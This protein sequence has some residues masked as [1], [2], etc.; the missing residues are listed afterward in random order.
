[1]LVAA[2][3]A[4]VCGPVQVEGQLGV[5]FADSFAANSDTQFL[6]IMN[7]RWMQN[8]IQ[9]NQITDL[10]N[11]GWKRGLRVTGDPGTHLIGWEDVYI[12]AFE[13]DLLMQAKDDIDGN[14]FDIDG[15]AEM[16]FEI[17]SVRRNVEMH[18]AND[19]DIN[20][21]YNSIF[22]GDRNVLVQ[23]Q[24]DDIETTSQHLTDVN[25]GTDIEIT[26]HNNVLLDSTTA[27]VQLNAQERDILMQAHDDVKLV[28]V[29]GD[30]E[31][32]SARDIN[33]C[34]QQDIRFLNQDPSEVLSPL[35]TEGGIIFITDCGE[36]QNYVAY[37]ENG[38]ATAGVDAG[39]KNIVLVSQGTEGGVVVSSAT[40]PP[41]NDV[42]TVSPRDII[43]HAARVRESDGQG[44]S[45]M[46]TE[47]TTES[48]ADVSLDVN[49]DIVSGRISAVAAALT[50]GVRF[51]T[52]GVDFDQQIRDNV[53]LYSVEFQAAGAG[54]GGKGAIL[55]TSTGEVT[56]AEAQNRDIV[57]H[58]PHSEPFSSSQALSVDGNN[59]VGG[60]IG[61]L[62]SR[63]RDSVTPLP[64]EIFVYSNSNPRGGAAGRKNGDVEFLTGSRTSTYTESPG[65]R[66]L[67][68]SNSPS[69]A[70]TSGIL[71]IA[72][73]VGSDGS[74]F[75][76][77]NN[78]ILVSAGRASGSMTISSGSEL[79][80]PRGNQ[81]ADIH[82]QA[83][84]VTGSVQFATGS[85]ELD[86]GFNR[87][88][89]F[90]ARAVTKSSVDDDKQRA[91]SLAF[92]VGAVKTEGGPPSI[93]F[94][95]DYG[96][97]V[98]LLAAEDEGGIA[99]LASDLSDS[100]I[101]ST[102]G[103]DG[104]PNTSRSVAAGFNDVAIATDNSHGG[105]IFNSGNTDKLPVAQKGGVIFL[106]PETTGGIFFGTA[107]VPV[108]NVEDNDVFAVS[109]GGVLI[110]TDLP[111][112]MQPRDADIGIISNAPTGGILQSL[113][114]L[115]SLPSLTPQAVSGS[116]LTVVDARL[117]GGIGI[118]TG[119]PSTTPSVD[120]GLPIDK[121]NI[122]INARRDSTPADG[123]VLTAGAV[124]VATGSVE[125]RD[126]ANPT[127]Q[128]IQ[129]NVV[130]NSNGKDGGIV[131]SLGDS[132]PAQ[133][134]SI[135]TN[136]D[137]RYEA[138]IA[139][140]TGAFTATLEQND[141]MLVSQN[142]GVAVGTG[143]VTTS[144]GGGPGNLLID[145]NDILVNAR[146]PNAGLVVS[147]GATVPQAQD[148][149]IILANMANRNTINGE[150]RG[151]IGFFTSNSNAAQNDIVVGENIILNS[152]TATN[153]GIL[154]RLGER[155]GTSTDAPDRHL[156][157][158]A[159]RDADG[160]GAN[161]A[162]DTLPQL[163]ALG[164]SKSVSFSAPGDRGGVTVSVID[165]SNDIFTTPVDHAISLICETVDSCSTLIA[166]GGTDDAADPSPIVPEPLDVVIQAS[167]LS[168]RLD[169]DDVGGV[170]MVAGQA[171]GSKFTSDNNIVVHAQFNDGGVTVAAGAT[172]PP[173]FDN[174]V[175]LH[176]PGAS[177]ESGILSGILSQVGFGDT[178]DLSDNLSND[179]IVFYTTEGDIRVESTGYN[180]EIDVRTL[181]GVAGTIDVKAGTVFV[182][183]K[184]D[185]PGVTSQPT[186]G[187]TSAPSGSVELTAGR[188]YVEEAEQVASFKSF[189][190]N[191]DITSLQNDVLINA[192]SGAVQIGA[193]GANSFGEG[194][195]G[196]VE[197]VANS[198]PTNGD[199]NDFSDIRF[200]GAELVQVSTTAGGSDI[201]VKSSTRTIQLA[202][203]VVW[204]TYPSDSARDIELFSDAGLTLTASG[205]AD[206][207]H[208]IIAQG[209][210]NLQSLDG[211][212]SFDALATAP[213]T[214]PVQGEVR[215]TSSN[216]L[217]S[218]ANAQHD[219]E[220]DV[221]D[222]LLRTNTGVAGLCFAAGLDNTLCDQF[223]NFNNAILFESQK[224]TLITSTTGHTVTAK[225]EGI[226]VNVPSTGGGIAV[227]ARSRADP[228]ATILPKQVQFSADGQF[229]TVA[230][231]G[232]FDSEF[233]LIHRVDEESL[234]YV[235]E[236]GGV[237]LYASNNDLNRAAE[238]LPGSRIP[239]DAQ[240]LVKAD[241]NI[242]FEALNGHVLF[243]EDNSVDT[244]MN[245]GGNIELQGRGGL[246]VLA[247]ENSQPGLKAPVLGQVFVLSLD[248]NESDGGDITMVGNS[249]INM[250]VT[251]GDLQ[252]VAYGINPVNAARPKS[253]VFHTIST[254]PVGTTNFD[255]ILDSLAEV[256]VQ[257]TTQLRGYGR[258]VKAQTLNSGAVV[259]YST[260]DVPDVPD[261]DNVE[262]HADGDAFITTTTTEATALKAA[263]LDGDIFVAT[264]GAKADVTFT[265]TEMTTNAG[266]IDLRGIGGVRILAATAGTA[267]NG[268]V[269]TTTTDATGTDGYGQVRFLGGGNVIVQSGDGKSTTTDSN[270]INVQLEAAAAEGS[271][272][273]S[274]APTQIQ[275]SVT[276]KANA[277]LED[278]FIR[279][280]LNV[281]GDTQFSGGPT[282]VRGSLSTKTKNEN[283]AGNG[284]TFQSQYVEFSSSNRLTSFLNHLVQGSD[285]P[286]V[287]GGFFS[288][289][290]NGN[291]FDR[292]VTFDFVN[293]Q[294]GN[295]VG[296]ATTDTQQINFHSTTTFDPQSNTAVNVKVRVSND[297]QFRGETIRTR[298]APVT[299]NTGDVV[300]QQGSFINHVLPATTA[301]A[302]QTD[303]F[304]PAF[305]AQGGDF[306]G[307]AA[308][309]ERGSTMIMPG[310]GIFGFGQNANGIS[311]SSGLAS[312]ST[313]YTFV[314]R[315]QDVTCP[316]SSTAINPTWTSPLDSH[317]GGIAST[318]LPG[319]DAFYAPSG[320]LIVSDGLVGSHTA[321]LEVGGLYG[322]RYTDTLNSRVDYK[323]DANTAPNPNYVLF[324]DGANSDLQTI[325]T[326]IPV[327]LMGDEQP[328]SDATFTIGTGTGRG[329]RARFFGKDINV[330]A[331]KAS[332]DTNTEGLFV[333]NMRY[334]WLEQ[335]IGI[336][337][338]PANNG[339]FMCAV[340]AANT[341]L[342]DFTRTGPVNTVTFNLF[343]YCDGP[344]DSSTAVSQ[345]SCCDGA[346]CPPSACDNTHNTELAAVS[347]FCSDCTAMRN[348]V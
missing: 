30:I 192:K 124:V 80:Q 78:D 154:L 228:L 43:F 177:D 191:V 218:L 46:T 329:D 89:A 247:T 149:A 75:L 188:D 98:V 302:E 139:A 18:A 215:I 108:S 219:I 198:E 296:D 325:Q 246:A 21:G 338:Y 240:V 216:Q 90:T 243:V 291:F 31:A 315:A 61:V 285:D 16:L 270:Q 152:R 104:R 212:I 60:G 184:D 221:G 19:I 281:D 304:V 10:G 102:I 272:I 242:A 147:A 140:V 273:I 309:S 308:G 45:F 36:G 168:N 183:T 260:H 305:F 83:P 129:S 85:V 67:F 222:V 1:M 280:D 120:L 176:A 7:T 81:R 17:Q 171:A 300:V 340:S 172:S 321:V 204:P 203:T 109:N 27:N 288:P 253:V 70:P 287:N 255:I 189:A 122:L 303:N 9:A 320:N 214:S 174:S 34:A 263:S 160:I 312:D 113:N 331:G 245:H 290:D 100:S 205:D 295:A 206:Y 105:V 268:I 311:Q 207:A 159:V 318:A 58:A 123:G 328:T 65:G 202:S 115:G 103:L 39:D 190:G 319:F 118:F 230:N 179:R 148:N 41:R 112:E 96:A 237:L 306:V 226:H 162:F 97:N 15:N 49:Q 197:I 330:S 195:V 106:A 35:D 326:S 150:E 345:D 14:A 136:A 77:T 55:I 157:V 233:G 289:R 12:R 107:D 317:W 132:V 5:M 99:I 223:V 208:D 84:P 266:G 25:A 169:L 137:G 314:V 95:G 57:V 229:M 145:D 180:G 53:Q 161:I 166:T 186:D 175:T 333:K 348:E 24:W 274:T 275:N 327:W 114:F 101:R 28:A 74:G 199:T 261:Q 130:L 259:F 251:Q 254:T 79:T 59:G 292:K 165:A 42:P 141:I 282:I 225:G 341:Q 257:A 234:S 76:P 337:P 40:E 69:D 334:L 256:E 32:K 52:S 286:D 142:G 238:F 144:I 3:L 164:R 56:P 63:V 323:T 232:E 94:T 342:Q 235:A 279:G 93:S 262:L 110:G 111:T 71:A 307:R 156:V 22:H 201:Q 33:I 48:T 267:D 26:A 210:V 153:G 167:G 294:F 13:N 117:Q 86:E 209:S 264:T 293:V 23:S 182:S 68:Q 196:N 62:N 332:G 284:A 4:V 8:T 187:V 11:E 6:T 135:I 116:V 82:I 346:A 211:G 72:G 29:D 125:L 336:G 339:D 347:F 244:L 231:A 194:T 2:S 224:D 217:K 51:A 134:K 213:T 38:V 119:D 73:R 178:T 66:I 299:V 249:G 47:S 258:N 310:Y 322:P 126:N 250:D 269:I 92:V 173:T 151:G 64:E 252:L 227:G 185:V 276:V 283:T 88:I 87:H 181:S 127:D 298:T 313:S 158:H 344:L 265:A 271:Q 277:Q 121:G 193:T 239:Y 248:T 133:R 54:V 138:S 324:N 131:V 278:T 297:Y 170:Y 128:S 220:A 236:R 335:D 241:E 91:G 50:G 343:G 37:G 200:V 316:S 44:I 155:G 146:L 301:N 20:S 143:S 163:P